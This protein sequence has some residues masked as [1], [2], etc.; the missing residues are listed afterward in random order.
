[1]HDEENMTSF[2]RFC[3]VDRLTTL[4]LVLLAIA[5]GA[6]GTPDSQYHDACALLG[7]RKYEDATALLRDI[8]IAA[9]EHGN[10]EAARLLAKAGPLIE[11]GEFDKAVEIL[12]TTYDIPDQEMYAY[13]LN[14]S[15]DDPLSD[16]AR[17]IVLLLRCKM[18]IPMIE[19]M[20]DS[21]PDD[22]GSYEFV[23]DGGPEWQI[24]SILEAEMPDYETHAEGMNANDA[25]I[26]NASFANTTVLPAFAS[27][28]ET[29]EKF[30]LG[31]RE[32]VDVKAREIQAAE[33]RRNAGPLDGRWAVVQTWNMD[34][35]AYFAS[36]SYW[37]VEN[38][39]IQMN[40]VW[41]TGERETW[42]MNWILH[43]SAS[44]VSIHDDDGRGWDFSYSTFPVE[45]VGTALTL[46]GIN[47]TLWQ[48]VLGKK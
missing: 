46:K 4:I 13:R 36:G 3:S 25:P 34:T 15:P 29:A 26:F 43:E 28:L 41:P 38:G 33:E 27:E 42:N 21:D 24:N 45:D 12:N 37:D 48:F 32:R 23:W 39:R 44:T 8:D 20:L 47:G 11:K 7:E 19:E 2:S 31:S 18:A 30:I 1:M 10:L 14:I 17:N 9:L 35:D 6:C 16:P 40:I 22:E 5:L